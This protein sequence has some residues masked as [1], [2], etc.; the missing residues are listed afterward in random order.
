M[1]YDFKHQDYYNILFIYIPFQ[2]ISS[3]CDFV[4]HIRKEN[5]PLM[6][7]NQNARNSLMYFKI[8][9]VFSRA[10]VRSLGQIARNEHDQYEQI[11]AFVLIQVHIGSR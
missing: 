7:G 8:K 4:E 2:L 10:H 9:K 5:G 1:N 3:P 6:K 11:I